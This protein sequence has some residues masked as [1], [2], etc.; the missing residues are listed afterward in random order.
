MCQAFGGPTTFWPQSK[1]PKHLGAA[2]RN[3]Q[4]FRTKYGQVP[5]GLFGG[6]ENCRPGYVDP[7]QGME[8]CGMVEFML[9]A[10]RL[11]TITGDPIWAD[12]CED[13]AFN[14]LPAALTA[15]LK[16]I[17][18]LT[19]PNMATADAR[20]HSPGIENGGPMFQFDP[21]NHRCC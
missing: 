9:S 1:D 12:R 19:A 20:D 5:G 11:V 8:T 16:A 17:R 21:N 15:D 6:D 18:Y 7:R 13:V 2:E 14:S 10:E 3:F 4:E